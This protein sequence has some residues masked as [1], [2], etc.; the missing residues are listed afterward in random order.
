VQLLLHEA[1]H[2]QHLIADFFQILVEAAGNVV[3]EVGRFHKKIPLMTGVRLHPI[4][5]CVNTAADICD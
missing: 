3:G 4:A 5:A 2:L 1:A